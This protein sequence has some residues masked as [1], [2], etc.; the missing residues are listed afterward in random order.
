MRAFLFTILLIIASF[1]GYTQASHPITSRT[2]SSYHLR[3]VEQ[4]SICDLTSP[5]ITKYLNGDSLALEI[6]QI[7]L[8]SFSF[9]KDSIVTYKA[10]TL[11][12][13]K[14]DE[15][16]NIDLFIYGT[17]FVDEQGEHEIIGFITRDGVVLSVSLTKGNLVFVFNLYPE[18]AEEKHN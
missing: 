17:A 4:I 1:V 10:D 16:K 3:Y 13:Y 11:L 14:Y 8:P 6:N 5:T 12:V 2:S 18:P 15:T 9:L 7:R